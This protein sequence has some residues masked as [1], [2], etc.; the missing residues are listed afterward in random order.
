MRLSSSPL[1]W[2]C[3]ALLAAA[4]STDPSPSL[5]AE[6]AGSTPNLG[7]YGR[8]SAGCLAPEYRQFDFW[9]GRW[10]A[11]FGGP[12]VSTS[13]IT[14]ELNGCAV[15][16]SFSAPG[17]FVGRSLNVY[18][19][20]R[21]RWSQ[22]YLDGQGFS[23]RL[24]GSFRDGGM[25]MADKIRPTTTGLKLYSTIDWTV[26][27]DQSVR[28]LWRLSFAG[29]DGLQD[30]SDGRYAAN[31]G[32]TPFP[33]GAPDFCVNRFPA[34]RQL[35]ALRGAWDV[36]ARSERVG[37]ATIRSTTG[38]CLIEVDLAGANDYRL[39]GFL[40]YDRFLRRWFYVTVDTNGEVMEFEGTV[41]NGVLTMDGTEPVRGGPVQKLKLTWQA[42]G[43]TRLEQTLVE[44]SRT[45]TYTFSR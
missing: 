25:R 20:E 33:D 32:A 9:V 11:T 24:F 8:G 17:G 16:E 35:D 29:T 41:T 22:T 23:L 36:A 37:A 6:P 7:L 27:P 13:I 21:R 4:C 43:P 14:T 38:D 28:Q 10:D 39:R 19:A 5:P 30:W 2:F 18:D 15:M 45:T 1:P 40:Q 44:P 34:F 12:G 26:N 42:V 31:P 3:V